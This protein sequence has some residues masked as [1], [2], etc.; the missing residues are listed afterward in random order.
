MVTV[1][2]TL[3]SVSLPRED[4]RL[5]VAICLSF[6]S[7]AVILLQPSKTMQKSDQIRQSVKT[8]CPG[9]AGKV[10]KP[11]LL[12]VAGQMEKLPVRCFLPT[13][14]KDWVGSSS[15]LSGLTSLIPKARILTV[16]SGEI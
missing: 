5:Q 6:L 12:L 13:V 11:R 7:M 3:D 16:N 9:P 14:S 4:M 1:P 2:F 15:L 10:N 8:R